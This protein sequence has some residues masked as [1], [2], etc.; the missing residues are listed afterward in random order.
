[1]KVQNVYRI[2]AAVILLAIGIQRAVAMHRP[3]SM[4]RYHEKIRVVAG[5]VPSNIAG[6]VGEDVAVPV[7]ATTV[8]RPNVMISR[9]YLNIENG[10]SAGVLLVHSSDAHAMAGHFPLRCYPARGWDVLEARPRD[11]Q[12]GDL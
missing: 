4:L 3:P 6:G 12:V 9:R 8:L 10:T 2:L 5:L 7:Q 1:M 11:W